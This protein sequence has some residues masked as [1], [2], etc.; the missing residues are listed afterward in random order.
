V[1]RPRRIHGRPAPGAG[2][3]RPGREEWGADRLRG[4]APP[5]RWPR[6]RPGPRRRSRTV[7][8]MLRSF[9]YGR[10]TTAANGPWAARHRDALLRG[11]RR[12]PP[13][14]D[15]R[16]TTR[17][18]IRAFE[19]RQRRST[20]HAY[21]G[22]PPSPPGSPSPLSGP[23]PPGRRP[24]P[25][26]T[27]P[28]DTPPTTRPPPRAPPPR[29]GGAAATTPPPPARPPPGGWSGGD[30]NS[31]SGAGGPSAAAV[32]ADS[33]SAR[34]RRVIRKRQPLGAGDRGP[35]RVGGPIRRSF[36]A[37]PFGA[38]PESSPARSCPAG[39]AGKLRDRP[40]TGGFGR[41]RQASPLPGTVPGPPRRGR[42]VAPAR[43]H[44]PTTR[45]GVLGA[46]PEADGN[47]HPRPLRPLRPPAWW[48]SALIE[49]KGGRP[50]EQGVWELEPEGDGLFSHPC[51]RRQTV[52]ETTG[53]R[54]RTTNG[55]ARGRRPVPLPPLGSAILDLHLIG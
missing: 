16:E 25:R 5:A 9:D 26:R 30:S 31:P 24:P 7:A 3:A 33:R 13:G 46:H 54:S 49:E 2:A 40:T 27:R 47:P 17:C 48:A 42:Q 10:P 12:R 1:D 23:G 15:P 50:K 29:S 22:A 34:L 39:G 6:R 19:N 35:G 52:A 41:E 20:R 36:P 55:R 44:P 28:C 53:S 32:V 37:A 51:C 14:T 8:G 45:N 11:V 43:R 18:L 21:G 4:R 38:P